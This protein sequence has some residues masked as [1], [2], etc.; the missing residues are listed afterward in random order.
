VKA[1]GWNQST[2]H[3]LD[4]VNIPDSDPDY[5]VSLMTL[6]AAYCP[7]PPGRPPRFSPFEN[8]TFTVP[9]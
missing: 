1:Y 8:H 7:L 9:S 3:N 2:G 5:K 4:G 6:P